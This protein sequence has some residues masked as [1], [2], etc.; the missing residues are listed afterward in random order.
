MYFFRESIKYV[1]TE[2]VYSI[3]GW[4]LGYL[5]FS[6]F[7]EYRFA[8]VLSLISRQLAK[9]FFKTEEKLQNNDCNFNNSLIEK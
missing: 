2:Q 1:E 3:N 4:K 7:L 5:L 9:T 8:H 6:L